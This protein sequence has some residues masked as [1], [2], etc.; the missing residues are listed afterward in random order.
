MADQGAQTFRSGE[1]TLVYHRVGSAA[2]PVVVLVHGIGM[3]RVVYAEL[4]EELSRSATVYAL[5]L[6]G[7]G[8]SLELDAPL[9]MPATG[10]LLAE[11]VR[12]LGLEDPVLVGHSMGGQVVAEALARHR[13][14]CSRAVLVAPSVNPAERSMPRQAV[15]MLQDLAGE[16]PKVLALGA[17]SYAKAGPRWFLRKMR[18]ML[19]HR[20]EETL[21]QIEAE[22]MVL[23]GDKDRVC[24]PAWMEKVADLI[25]AAYL[26]AIPG[27]G[28]EA[29][30]ST[31]Q[32]AARLILEH[33]QSG[34]P[35]AEVTV[36]Q[37]N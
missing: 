12:G 14:L 26:R 21:P 18:Q 28:H 19:A 35:R 2:Q 1:H 22:V 29:V 33:A 8:D 25:P 11:F 30:I 16:S 4:V 6:P 7:F 34:K 36:R 24:P 15:R 9:S 10:D 37:R 13:Q 23:Y 20:L 17:Y 32:P 31:G 3:G 27:T 5:D